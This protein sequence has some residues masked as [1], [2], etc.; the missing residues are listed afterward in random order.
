MLPGDPPRILSIRSRT[1]LFPSS[2]RAR[3]TSADV[4]LWY[5]VDERGEVVLLMLEQRVW[6]SAP[7]Q[8][9]QL[10]EKFNRYLSFVL[11]GFLAE[12][13]PQ[14]KDQPV[15]FRLDCAGPPGDAAPGTI[16]VTRGRHAK[17]VISQVDG[18]VAV[19]DG[20]V[21]GTLYAYNYARMPLCARA[22]DWTTG[23]YKGLL[24]GM[25]KP[26]DRP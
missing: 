6:G 24:L 13:F 3:G 7:G 8:L 5:V 23:S 16:L 1:P 18:D 19:I 10:E 14:Y 20:V 25:Y 26:I 21:A 22:K 9:R 17:D 2:E 12:Q 11:D 15:C 4:V